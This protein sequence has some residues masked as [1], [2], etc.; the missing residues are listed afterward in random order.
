MD[1]P[2]PVLLSH[3]A[4]VSVSGPDAPTFLEGLL[5]QSVLK[6][7]AGQS[8]HGALL[9]PQGKVIADM[10]I[11]RLGEGFGLDCDAGAAAALVRRLTLF[12]LRAKVDVALRDDLGVIA[13]AGPADPRSSDAPHREID[14]RANAPT[15]ETLVYHAARIAAGVA[16]QGIDFGAEEVFP[17]DINM[18]ITGG[19]DFRKGCF[20]GQEVVSRMKRRGTARRRTLA[21]RFDGE[22][23]QAP[24]PVMADGGEIGTLTS[25][26]SGIGLVRVRVDRLAEAEAKGEQASAGGAALGIVRPD[27]LAVEIAALAR[28]KDGGQ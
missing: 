10:I 24:A 17:A 7:D 8:R 1:M 13:F 14:V 6:L 18:D 28:P 3:R 9:T 21:A 11:H 23:P 19:V 20:V 26:A 22:A 5:T 15:G 16:E 27:W 4:I 12:R 25:L 2:D